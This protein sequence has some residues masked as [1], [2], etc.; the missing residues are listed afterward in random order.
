MKGGY[1]DLEEDQKAFERTLNQRISSIVAR[2]VQE[3]LQNY[4]DICKNF[5]QFFNSEFLQEKFD[6]KLDVR[7]YDRQIREKSSIR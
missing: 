2:V 6:E 4:D 5:G 7:T 3:R 1:A